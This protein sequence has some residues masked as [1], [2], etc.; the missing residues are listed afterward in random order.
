[1]IDIKVTHPNHA[2]ATAEAGKCLKGASVTHQV[3]GG[4][5]SFV[6]AIQFERGCIALKAAGFTI[7]NY[8]THGNYSN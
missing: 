2:D 8:G 7:S 5:I 1:M 6:D 3:N 4:R